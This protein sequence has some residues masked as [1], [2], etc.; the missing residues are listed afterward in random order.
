[1][2]FL[3]SLFWCLLAF[4]AAI[5]TYGNWRHVEVQLWGGSVADVNLPVMLFAAFMAGLIPAW[6]W[7][8]AVRWRLR[9]RLAQAERASYVPVA[10]AEPAQP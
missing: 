3:Q 8:H 7:G 6:A 9:Q 1:M 4:V 10:P 5:F 2:R